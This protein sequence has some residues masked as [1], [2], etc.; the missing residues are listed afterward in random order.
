MVPD[1]YTLPPLLLA[2]CKASPILNPIFASMNEDQMSSMFSRICNHSS[3]SSMPFVDKDVHHLYEC[4]KKQGIHRE[5]LLEFV[6]CLKACYQDL[7]PDRDISSQPLIHEV[8]KLI[9]K[10]VQHEET[11]TRTIIDDII[12][13]LKNTDLA[14]DR[15]NIINRLM[16][17]SAIIRE[18][19]GC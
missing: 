4:H 6:N 3:C 8:V 18:R 11:C 1:V 17:V 13:D 9:H 19:F 2:K 5:H 15:N 7:Y 12:H 14:I 10:I 16:R